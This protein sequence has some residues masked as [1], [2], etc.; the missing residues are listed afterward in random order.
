MTLETVQDFIAFS[1]NQ[2]P[3]VTAV[4]TSL[5]VLVYA[6]VTS[7]LRQFGLRYGFLLIVSIMFYLLAQEMR[8]PSNRAN[9]QFFEGLSNELLG[10]AIVLILIGRWAFAASWWFFPVVFFVFGLEI[11]IDFVPSQFQ[12]FF[13]GIVSNVWGAFLVAIL[14]EREWLW[15]AGEHHTS[16]LQLSRLE[17]L[18][19]KQ[20]AVERQVRDEVIHKR[21]QHL[22]GLRQQLRRQHAALPSAQPPECDLYIKVRGRDAA[23]IKAKMKHI[24]AVLGNVRVK[25]VQRVAETGEFRCLATANLPGTA[26]AGPVSVKQSA[27][28]ATPKE[29]PARPAAPVI[30]PSRPGA[31]SGRPKVP[32]WL[33]SEDEETQEAS[34]MTAD[35]DQPS[36]SARL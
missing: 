23:D 18:Q 26:I 16:R 11:A 36:A 24:E 33:A 9:Q 5:V 20:A 21:K 13:I 34:A 7:R 3:L 8:T 31:G 12:A 4:I 27:P 1:I 17:R 25:D 2:N 30:L 15:T 10:T 35:Q 19:L 6:V 29:S 28:I 32:T 14:L 22:S